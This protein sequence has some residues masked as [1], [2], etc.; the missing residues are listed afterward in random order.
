MKKA[1]QEAT[2]GNVDYVIGEQDLVQFSLTTDGI[3]MMQYT[4]SGPQP[5]R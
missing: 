2:S 5:Q 4:A 3:L 1:C